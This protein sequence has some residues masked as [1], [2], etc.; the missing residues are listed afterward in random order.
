[1]SHAAM[2]ALQIPGPH[3]CPA[4]DPAP[5]I[6]RTYATRLFDLINATHE[7]PARTQLSTPRGALRMQLRCR[8]ITH[9][10]TMDA[11]PGTCRQSGQTR[12]SSHLH[13]MR[14]GCCCARREGCLPVSPSLM[15]ISPATTLRSYISAAM[16][17][18]PPKCTF[19]KSSSLDRQLCN[20]TDTSCLSLLQIVR[21]ALLREIPCRR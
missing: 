2:L 11:Q 21:H 4:A 20:P 19:P 17:R 8:P 3:E 9:L 6:A 18:S 15:R 16:R 12:F 1:M 5:P 10:A 14:A 13:R 7:Q